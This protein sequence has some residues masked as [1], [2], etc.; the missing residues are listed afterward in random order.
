[1]KHLI[2]KQYKVEI[3]VEND[4]D[5]V[6]DG[7]ADART[8]IE[9]LGLKILKVERLKS[10]RSEKQ[11]NALHKW[12]AML[13]EEFNENGLDVRE[14]VRKD[15]T[16]PW[17]GNLVKEVL[18]KKIQSSL[19]GKKSTTELDRDKEINLIY[20]TINRVLIER[21]KGNIN[22]PPFPSIEVQE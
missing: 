17:T 8:T 19:T 13:A 1:M 22:V 3:V 4:K 16:I 21:F 5:T 9:G 18:W 2:P 12:F 6:L 7:I 14:V 10:I 15:Y 20:D 11:N